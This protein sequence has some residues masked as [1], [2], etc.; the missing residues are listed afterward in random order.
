MINS[1]NFHG[2]IGKI[3]DV[4]VFKGFMHIKYLEY[5]STEA[6]FQRNIDRE[7]IKN[8]I[9]F[10]DNDNKEFKIFLKL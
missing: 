10:I 1:L 7:H 2:I 8:I 5:F 9:D 6:D 4:E 3:F